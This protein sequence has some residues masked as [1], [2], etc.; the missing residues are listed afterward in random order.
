MNVVKFLKKYK[1]KIIITIFL[2]CMG[3][4]YF[5]SVEGY[6]NVRNNIQKKSPITKYLQRFRKKKIGIRQ[7]NNRSII[8]SHRDKLFKDRQKSWGRVTKHKEGKT[9]VNIPRERTKALRW[10]GE[11]NKKRNGLGGNE[12]GGFAQRGG[13]RLN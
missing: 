7:N 3:Y 6:S 8:L 2:L 11:K 4:S 10:R 12:R 9:N 1:V 13:R 5:K